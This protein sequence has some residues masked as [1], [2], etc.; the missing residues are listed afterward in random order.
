MGSSPHTSPFLFFNAQHG[1]YCLYSQTPSEEAEREGFPANAL[2]G[3]LVV[4][5][6]YPF[7]WP[8]L[9][10]GTPIFQRVF[11]Q[12]ASPSIWPAVQSLW[13]GLSTNLGVTMWYVCGCSWRDD[14]CCVCECYR[15]CIVLMDVIWHRLCVSMFSERVIYLFW[16]GQGY[17]EWGRE[18][19]GR[20]SLELFMCGG[21]CAQYFIASCG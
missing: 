21:G 8:L 2:N 13:W 11:H 4:V 12:P 17:D 15:G 9:L 6:V 19:L 1:T 10:G 18:V 20:I 14:V 5:V 16:V 7:P 3:I